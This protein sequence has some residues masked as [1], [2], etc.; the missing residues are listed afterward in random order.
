MSKELSPDTTLSH[1]RIVSKIGAGGMG[2][3]YLAQDTKLDRKVALKILPAEVAAN[4]GRLERFRREARA[5]AALNHPH[6]V[7]IYSVEEADGVHFL[8]MELVEGQALDRLI[9]ESGL[10]LNRLLGIA[11]AFVDAL[12]AAHKKGIVHRDLKPANVMVTKDGR[13]KLLDFGLAK[14]AGPRGGAQADSELPTEMLTREGLVLGTVPYMSP[15]QV[16]GRA[17]DHRTDLFSVGVIL[18]EMA[19]GRRPFEGGSTAELA[20]AILRDTPPVVTEVRSDLPGKL[21]HIIRR[22]LEKDARQRF[23]TARELVNGLRDLVGESGTTREAFAGIEIVPPVPSVTAGRERHPFVGRDQERAALGRM[24]EETAQGRGGVVLLGGEP[25]VGKTRLAEELL[26]DGR[27]RGMLALTGHAYEEEGVPFITEVEILEEMAR[28]VPAADL[29]RRLGDDAS[30]IARLMPELRRRFADITDSIELPPE[31]QRRYFFNSVLAFLERASREQPM[32]M[33]LDDLHWADESSLLLLEHLAPHLRGMSLLMLGTYRDV[34]ADIGKPFEKTLARLVR[35]HPAERMPIKRLSEASVAALLA[36]LGGEGPPATLVAAIYRETEGN[37]F[38]VEEVFRHLSEEGRL[39]DDEGR[40]KLDLNV[41]EMDVPTGVRLVIGCRLERLSKEVPKVLTAAAVIGRLFELRL[42]E[43][44]SDLDADAFLDTIEEAEAAQL[45]A[46]VTGSRETRY[47]FVHELIRQTLLGTLSNP[48]RQRLHVR[49]AEAI[50]SL[51]GNRAEERAADLA[52]HLFQAGPAADVQKTIRYLESAGDRALEATAAEEARRFFDSALSLVADHDDSARANLLRRRA[53]A[54]QSLAAFSDW[55]S[56]LTSALS[57]LERSGDAEA[58]AEV[59]Y[60][61]AYRLV[62]E[63]RADEASK[64]AQRGFGLLGDQSS[65]GRVRLLSMRAMALSMACQSDEGGQAH[66]EAVRLAEELGDPG[67]LGEVLANQAMHYWEILN[68]AELAR[69]AE[70]AEEYNRAQRKIRQLARSMFLAQLGWAMLGRHE[71]AEAKNAELASLAESLG[72]PGVVMMMMSGMANQLAC[73][74]RGGLDEALRFAERAR[75]LCRRVSLPWPD[76]FGGLVGM[77]QLFMG[78]WD[79][80]RATFD[81]IGQGLAPPGTVWVHGERGHK[82]LGKAYLG[83]PDAL[84]IYRRLRAEVLDQGQFGRAGAKWVLLDSAQALVLLGQRE[85]AARLY[86]A[87]SAIARSGA[88]VVDFSSG[89][90]EKTAGIAATAASDWDAAERHF[91]T[92]SHLAEGLRLCVEQ[93]EVR[94]WYARM[95]LDRDGPGDRE[96][97]RT[98]LTEARNAYQEIGMPKHV[99]MVN[100]MKEVS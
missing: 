56:D 99:E 43:V 88:L 13:V 39:L 65:P 41:N 30:E 94:R 78:R 20:S 12:V 23:Q 51:L 50:E 11:V 29:R 72:G 28:L 15:E 4:P 97:A 19:S 44:L 38:F 80:A 3:V 5:V 45:I 25:G 59:C 92:A 77:M 58:A 98:F 27:E 60:D 91:Q 35:Q 64:L 18:Y 31:Q 63:G 85:E 81:G 71:K 87:I 76:T 24:L 10:P 57:S 93:P 62:Y 26:A 22:C 6:I 40:W 49:V 9:P 69:V 36:A 54:H 95:L 83:D 73:V 74:S 86:P 61:L 1:Y 90:V 42:V 66:L 7:T 79:E 52:H 2:E 82:L 67:L 46:P 53:L 33:L 84:E 21:A 8:T 89:L 55:K 75:Q 16:S 17:V 68:G 96:R 14:V 100:K 48:R 47:E 37:P 34:E 32:V 70:R